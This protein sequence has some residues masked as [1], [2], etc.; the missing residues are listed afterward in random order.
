MVP[1]RSRPQGAPQ[2]RRGIPEL[3]EARLHIANPTI[4]ALGSRSIKTSIDSATALYIFLGILISLCIA[5]P[6][7]RHLRG[8]QTKDVTGYI[9]RAKRATVELNGK[10]AEL[11]ALKQRHETLLQEQEPLQTL[12]Q[13]QENELKDARLQSQRLEMRIVDLEQSRRAGEETLAEAKMDAD[14]AHEELRAARL[15]SQMLEAQINSL[16]QSKAN[17]EEAKRD[18]DRAQYELRDARL[19]SQTLQGR[20]NDLEQF[21]HDG[22]AAL[23][24]ALRDKNRALEEVREARQSH[25][26]SLETIR[27]LAREI[28]AK[29]EVLTSLQQRYNY[30]D[31]E[32]RQ[33]MSIM[34]GTET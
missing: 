23:A 19:Q 4:H 34:A 24:G 3:H 33:L 2:S 8:K 20:I 28:Q 29:E 14:T 12:L 11:A 16:K 13:Q 6:L 31:Q 17:F 1:P 27:N 25:S 9:E 30:V 26:A 5:A 10:V 7:V 15:K 22:Q 18:R 32:Y 21:R